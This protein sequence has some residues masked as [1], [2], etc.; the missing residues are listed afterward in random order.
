MDAAAGRVK[1]TF[2]IFVGGNIQQQD[3]CIKI[4]LLLLVA[5]S[6]FPRPFCAVM[7]RV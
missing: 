4:S 6:I 7:V 1:E 2:L 5:Q 3:A